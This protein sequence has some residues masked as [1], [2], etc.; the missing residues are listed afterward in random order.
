VTA[1][2]DGNTARKAKATVRDLSGPE[3]TWLEQAVVSV[4]HRLGEQASG[5]PLTPIT[6]NS[7][8]LP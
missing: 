4:I 5:S 8:P 2:G 1:K 6:L 3:K 7:F